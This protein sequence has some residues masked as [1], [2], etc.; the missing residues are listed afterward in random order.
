MV[1]FQWLIGGEAGNGI[2]TT[3]AMMSKILTRLGMYVFDYTEYPSLIRGGHNAYYVHAGEVEVF[4]QKREVDILVALNRETIEKHLEELSENA[5]IIYDPKTFKFDFANVHKNIS[6]FEVPLLEI[7]HK[8]KTSRYMMNMVSLGASLGLIYEDFGIL[9]SLIKEQF[10]GKGE[11]V[12]S[13]NLN[14]AK[15]G[16]DYVKNNFAAKFHIKIIKRD[17]SNLLIGGIDAVTIGSIKAGLKFAAIYPMT[18]TSGIIPELAKNALE[19]KIIIKEPEDEI[20]GINMAIGAG[21]AGVRSMVATSGGGFSLMTEGVGLAAQAEVP[22]VI[23]MG[24]RPGPATGMP[25]WTSQGDLRFI[26]HAAQDEFPRVVLTPGDHLETL[27]LTMKAY[28]LAEKYQMPVIVLV[29]KY[30]MEG[31]KT[32]AVKEVDDLLKA[33]K[34]E[35]GK[36]LTDEEALK[37]TDYKRYLITEDGVSPRSIPGQKGAIAL[38]GSDE[39]DE[40][41]LYNEESENRIKMMDKRFRKVES[42]IRDIDPPDFY[43]WQDAEITLISWGSN[44]FPIF[45]AMKLLKKKGVNINYLHVTCMYPFPAREIAS[46]IKAAKNTLVVEGNK[47]G[48]FE[49]LIKEHTGLSIRDSL[50]KYDGRP[51]YPDEIIKKVQALL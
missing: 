21:F 29:D 45:E 8:Y 1:D 41:G 4:S 48:Q 9:E 11:K 14:L 27:K 47:T 40:R 23:I 30:L 15:D 46:V 10:S 44:K 31:H 16:F 25:T 28:N 24:M 50:R 18:P 3:G 42:L 17:E 19:H 26:L 39:H 20:S 32:E 22:V 2:M 34:I 35:R 7:V 49:G 36:I 12:V 51:F 43:G 6:V 5:C 37:K 13:E 38:S 33:Y